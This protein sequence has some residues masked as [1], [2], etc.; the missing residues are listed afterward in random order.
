MSSGAIKM[1]TESKTAPQRK[2]WNGYRPGHPWFYVLGGMVLMPKE[3][4]TEVKASGYQGY[5]ADTIA[6][7]D[8]KPEPQRSESLRQIRAK[9]HCDLI[10]DLSCYRECARELHQYRITAIYNG[11]GPECREIH[12][13]ISLKHNHLY[14]DFAHLVRLDKLLSRQPD[15]FGD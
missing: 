15:L 11:G 8:N 5:M 13:S 10:S 12:T 4:L 7:A 14:N 9:V 3:I 2:S 6:K 1:A